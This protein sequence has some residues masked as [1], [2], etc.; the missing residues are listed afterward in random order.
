MAELTASAT[1]VGEREE[2][3]AKDCGKRWRIVLAAQV[4]SRTMDRN[5]GLIPAG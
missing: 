2:S 4:E 3:D 5:G 1:K